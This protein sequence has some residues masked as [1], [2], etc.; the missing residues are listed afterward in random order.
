MTDTGVPA[1]NS[2]FN[3][4]CVLVTAA[5]VLTFVPGVRLRERCLLSVRDRGT[6]LCVFLILGL[7]EELSDSHSGWLN[8]RI[9]S[10]CAAGLVAGPWVGMVVSVFVT[11][12]AVSYDGLPLG[13]IGI[14]MLCGGLA[15][16]WLYRR[17]P[18]LA[19]HPITGFCLTVIVSWLRGGL[20]MWAVPGARTGPQILEQMGVAPVLQGLGTAL[21][22]AIVAHVRARDEQSKAAV[23]AEVR[24]LQARMNPHFLFNA[25]NALAALATVAPREI[26]R[27][28]GR[29]RHFLRASFDQH[30]RV[31]VPL[32][33]ELAVVHAYLDIESLRLGTRLKVEEMIDP[34]LVEVLIPPFSLQPLVENAVQHGLQSSAKAGRLHLAVHQEG[35]SLE[36]SVTDDGQGVPSADVEKIFFSGHSQV[37]ALEV[38]RRRLHGLF[39]RSFRLE[40]SSHVGQGTTVTLSIPLRMQF[41]VSGRLFESDA[42]APGRLASG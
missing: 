13:S 42:P 11:W 29:L 40:V 1:M 8:E 39:G 26:P 31:L 41:E 6:A 37:H 19:E 7:I 12:L 20:T 18:R 27:A 10:V 21:I 9:V 34:G 2:I 15:G 23:S 35:Q 3:A 36:M 28:A 5:F 14:S 17:R 32:R 25:L 4:L 33:E 30:E 38:L 24:A 22:L 16:G